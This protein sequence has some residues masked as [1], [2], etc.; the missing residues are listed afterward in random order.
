MKHMLR[1][2]K[3]GKNMR[4][5]K[6]IVVS[7]AIAVGCIVGTLVL[8]FTSSDPSSVIISYVL[9]LFTL[10]PM[11]YLIEN[12]NDRAIALVT[13][14][15]ESSEELLSMAKQLL[16]VNRQL[17]FE[18]KVIALLLKKQK[19]VT[20]DVLQVQNLPMLKHFMEEIE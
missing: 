17:K 7:V 3:K 9:G 5:D 2:Q 12:I 6:D 14:L 20:T 15:L 19:Q 8:L 4:V 11:L 10:L 16:T 18:L 13:D 1:R